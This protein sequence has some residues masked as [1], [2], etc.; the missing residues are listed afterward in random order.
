M[1][2]G[3]EE[4]H[5][6][7]LIKVKEYIEKN[8]KEKVKRQTGIR[9]CQALHLEEGEDV[10]DYDYRSEVRSSEKEKRFVESFE[11]IFKIYWLSSGC[12]SNIKNSEKLEEALKIY[13][14]LYDRTLEVLIEIGEVG[15]LKIEG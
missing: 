8:T 3:S 11:F 1:T 14:K 2:D 10:V 5:I 15:Y 7:D 9:L 4:K 12:V 6:E 13:R